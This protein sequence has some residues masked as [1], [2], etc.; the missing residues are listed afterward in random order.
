MP[1]YRAYGLTIDSEL[2]L[3]ELRPAP[4]GASDTPDLTVRR[5]AVP[6]GELPTGQQITPYLW[7]DSQSVRLSIPGVAHFFISGGDTITVDPAPGVDADS[8][9]LFLLGSALGSALFQ[10]GYLVLHGNAVQVGER[11]MC[12]LGVSGAGK[13]TLAAGFWRRGHAVLADDVVAVDAQCRALPAF[14]RIKLWQDSADQLNV[15]TAKLRRIRPIEAKFNLPIPAPADTALPIRWV[16]ILDSH[17]GP[18]LRLEHVSG[19]AKFAPLHDNTYGVR[20]VEGM[21]LRSE[22]L[23]LCGQLAG[24]IRLVKVTRPRQGFRLND[25]IDALLADMA[26]NP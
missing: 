3:P 9:R 23:R 5:D 11:C 13:S 4:H 2:E 16:Y 17:E 1:L 25:L 26:Q 7:A 21:S 12:C 15:D 19:L 22:H 14:P 10:R 6:A 24:R 8:V 18:D 20:I